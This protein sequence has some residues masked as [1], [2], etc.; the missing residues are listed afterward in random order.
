ML[1]TLR[2]FR[3]EYI[4]HIRDKRCPAGQC[5]NLVDIKIDPDKC[6][7]CGICAKSCPVNAISGE[8]KSPYKIDPTICTKCRT[9][10]A[11]CP[12]KAIS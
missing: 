10:I 8:L 5:K 1:S 4:A 6:K 3:D 11:K 12:F 9:C 7:G 2:Y